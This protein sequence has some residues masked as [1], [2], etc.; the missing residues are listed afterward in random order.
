VPKAARM[1]ASRLRLDSGDWEEVSLI[2]E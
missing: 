2:E 1:L